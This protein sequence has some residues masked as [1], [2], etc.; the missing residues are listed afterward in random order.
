MKILPMFINT[1]GMPDLV[2]HTVKH[3][4]GDREREAWDRVPAGSVSASAAWTRVRREA[5]YPPRRG[6]FPEPRWWDGPWLKHVLGAHESGYGP[7][8]ALL[9]ERAGNPASPRWEAAERRRRIA[10]QEGFHL[11]VDAA[12]E[13]FQVVTAYFRVIFS[14]VASAPRPGPPLRAFAARGNCPPGAA[15]SVTGGEKK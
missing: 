3:F 11:V 15:P 8:Y 10:D 5:G 7:R 9:I 2:H 1:P 14:E 12:G 13:D 4:L 6:R